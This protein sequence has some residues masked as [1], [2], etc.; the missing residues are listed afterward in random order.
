METP[1]PP[2]NASFVVYACNLLRRVQRRVSLRESAIIIINYL[3]FIFI[4]W[5]ETLHTVSTQASQHLTFAQHSISVSH[6]LHNTLSKGGVGG[7]GRL[8]QWSPAHPSQAA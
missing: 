4:R 7:Y 3:I 6:A 5:S 2:C 1:A 8:P